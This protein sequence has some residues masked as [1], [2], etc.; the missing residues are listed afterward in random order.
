MRR[1]VSGDDGSFPRAV[2]IEAL[3]QVGCKISKGFDTDEVV[4]EDDDG[5]IEHHYLPDP[6]DYKMVQYL[7]RKFSPERF[8]PALTRRPPN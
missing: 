4:V 5:E 8:I 2:V 1:P 3:L 6:V 7:I